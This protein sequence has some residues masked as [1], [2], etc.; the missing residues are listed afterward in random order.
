MSPLD[1]LAH[2]ADVPIDVQVVL[3]RRSMTMRDVLALEAGSTLRM[4]R[5]A[6][7]NVDMYLGDVL[8]GTGEIVVIEQA[9]GV[10]IT[11]FSQ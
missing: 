1:E 10:R 9:M 4:T 11:D 6:G 7:E 2:L 3:D 8:L 5:A